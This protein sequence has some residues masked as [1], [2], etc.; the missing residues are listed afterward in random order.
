MSEA[1]KVSVQYGD[2]NGTTSFDGHSTSSEAIFKLAEKSDM[3][4]GFIPVGF[5]LFR[6]NPDE[7]GSIP[8]TLFASKA[9]ESGNSMMEVVSHAKTEEE[10]RVYRFEGK[11]SPNDFPA[12]FKRICIIAT[13]KNIPA[14]KVVFGT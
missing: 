8:F 6:L 10:L 13:M 9:D 5:E 1:F 4:E 2:L 14:D 3:P 11:L 12:L 7:S